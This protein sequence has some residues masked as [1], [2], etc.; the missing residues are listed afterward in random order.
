MFYL[1]NN[2]TALKRLTEEIRS[3]FGAYDDVRLGTALSSCKYLQ[4]VVNESLRI[5]PSLPG[6]LPREV[7]PGGVTVAGEKFPAGVDVAIPVYAMHHTCN[8]P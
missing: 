2:P 8:P 4:A 3:T 6:S 1:T 5:S 7:L